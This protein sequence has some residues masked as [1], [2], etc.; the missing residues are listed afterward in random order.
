MLPDFLT[1]VRLCNVNK[2]IT[3]FLLSYDIL[4]INISFNMFESVL[5]YSYL[6][7]SASG[8][9]HLLPLFLN[10]HIYK[11]AQIILGINF[12]LNF[13]RITNYVFMALVNKTTRISYSEFLVE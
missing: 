2:G 13:C 11:N 6:Q 9:I 8:E 1:Y 3:N 4:T 12:P 5:F 10:L 7:L